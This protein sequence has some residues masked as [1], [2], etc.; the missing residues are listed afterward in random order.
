MTEERRNAEEC[1]EAGKH[2][3]CNLQILEAEPDG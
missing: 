3:Q 1:R 2:E